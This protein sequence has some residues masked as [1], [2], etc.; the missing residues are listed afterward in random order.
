MKKATLIES[1]QRVDTIFD[2]I[3]Q[4]ASRSDVIR[5][6]SEEYGIGER[7]S[8]VYMK[9]ARELM[10]ADAEKARSDNFAIAV[11]RYNRL[12]AKN[13]KIQDFRECRNVQQALDKLTGVAAPAQEQPRQTK[14]TSLMPKKKAK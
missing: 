9:K 12:F 2:M 14:L 11:A 3:L 6:C 5:Y 8:E 13:Y 1:A 10:Q 4:G 7:Q